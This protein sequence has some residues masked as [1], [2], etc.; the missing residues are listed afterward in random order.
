MV[1]TLF[2]A[3]PAGAGGVWDW[4][5]GWEVGGALEN[6]PCGSIGPW[7]GGGCGIMRFA[8]NGR[9]GFYT[10]AGASHA[11]RRTGRVAPSSA[12]CTCG[13][14]LTAAR[15]VAPHKKRWPGRAGWELYTP[16]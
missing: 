10:K 16:R 12:G 3:T 4:A 15:E 1:G 9:I 11:S 7:P 8:R 14:Y 6:A 5:G 2:W 13:A